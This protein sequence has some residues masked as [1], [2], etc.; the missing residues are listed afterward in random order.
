M[1][2]LAPSHAADKRRL[3]AVVFTDVV[4]YSTRMQRDE[5]ATIAAVQADFARMREACAERGGEI[6]N[7]MGDGMLMCFSSVVEAV[8]CA[9]DIQ[10][11]FGTRK[12]ARAG[13][14]PLE[15]RIGVHLGDVFRTEDGQVAGD[16]V[17]IAARLESK[18]PVGGVCVSQNVY[19][20]VKG[21]VPM[22]ARFAGAQEL[23]NIGDPILAWH[24][25]PEG[26]GSF[27]DESKADTAAKPRLNAKNRAFAIFVAIIMV[28]AVASAWIWK[29]RN[30]SLTKIE[31][32][33]TDPSIAV[34]PFT[35]MSDDKDA[36]YF[37][38]GVHEDLLTQLASLGAL[39]V[40]SRTS[41]MEYRNTAKKM[42]DIGEELHV[43]YLVEGSV[44]RVKDQVRVTAQLINARNDQHVWAKNYDRKLADIFAIQSEVSK[45]IAEELR[46]SLTKPEAERLERR[47][48][49]NFAAYDLYLQ[50]QESAN[51]TQGTFRATM[52]YRE[53]IAM[54]E[55]A[56]ELDPKFAIAW[57]R[58]GVEY[59]RAYHQDVART[60][61]GRQKAKDAIARAIALAPDNVDVRLAEGTTYR[62]LD[63]I[64]H[65]TQAVESVVQVAPNNVRALLQLAYARE[66]QNRW[67]ESVAMLEKVLEVDPRN[68]AALVTYERTMVNFRRYD[69][70]L[71]A[72]R[73]IQA[74]RPNDL[75]WI[76]RYYW[77]GYQR[78]GSWDEL[79]RWRAT[80]P[81]DAY[82]NSWE[83]WI[84][85]IRY[86]QAHGDFDEVVRLADDPGE[87]TKARNRPAERMLES[88]DA[89]HAKGDKK[90][91]MA[92]AHA[93]LKEVDRWRRNHPED[94]DIVM[95]AAEAHAIL[96]DRDAAYKEHA[97]AMALARANRNAREIAGTYQSTAWLSAL[98]GDKDSAIKE[99]SRRI[100]FP[101]NAISY[102]VTN[103]AYASLRDDP[104]YKAL[105]ADPANNAPISYDVKDTEALK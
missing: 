103:S 53:R 83:L 29:G 3:A 84:V 22:Q 78:S 21:K 82:K 90:R 42:R 98:L 48:T 13:E 95:S 36:G 94:V 40:V 60:V 88:A 20:T 2:E 99:L 24:L 16:G 65:A 75:E 34:L 89:Y 97:R 92:V 23:K 51:A 45:A 68:L 58:L 30:A 52:T 104:R 44:R 91:A 43:S 63:D 27:P 7:T 96:G 100:N 28:A 73:R 86:A 105:I 93:T 54:L 87:P 37:A 32:A 17:N 77:I 1:S 56:V 62:N 57:S 70:A 61:E 69:K 31:T 12:S 33:A 38:D 67:P 47:P 39:K 101:G 55:K 15:H 10:R 59:S 26:V 18:A 49:E 8:S 9:L 71:E 64:E 46:V 76:A 5:R 25:L 79:E 14:A 50:A 19:E 66:I 41:V 72:N 4:G 74:I 35:N 80:L 102:V 81:K 6:L 11:E 85:D